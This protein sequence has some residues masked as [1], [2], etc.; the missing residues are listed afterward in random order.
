M[1]LE[2]FPY[3]QVGA[4]W[5]ARRERGGLLDIPG[6]G[7]TAQAIRAIDLRR[8]KRGIV[9]CPAH[10]R[11]NWRGEF[12]KF[13]HFERKIS[14]ARSIHDFV[15]FSRGIFD[16]LLL[17]YEMAV[18]WTPHFHEHAELLDFAV[19]D[20]CHYVNNLET[21]RAK[22]LLGPEGNGAG[23]LTQWAVQTWCLTGTLL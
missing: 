2:L 4:D 10:V 11:E 16:I 13:S 15:A 17:S 5:L 9:I 3:Q 21:K 7:K 23:G 12:Q 20:E 14:K 1:A 6:L 22:A 18:K 8:G 19:L